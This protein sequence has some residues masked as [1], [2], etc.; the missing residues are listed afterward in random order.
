LAKHPRSWE[1][2]R[3]RCLEAFLVEP[4]DPADSAR[5]GARA[6]IG[7]PFDPT[8]LPERTAQLLGSR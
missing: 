1:R 2:P 4:L 7:N 6:F 5:R 8:R 3:A